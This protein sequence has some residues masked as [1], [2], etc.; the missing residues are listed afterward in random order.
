MNFCRL[1]FFDAKWY[2]CLHEIVAAYF[3]WK[4]LGATPNCFLKLFEKWDKVLKPVMSAISETV[5][6]PSASNSAARLSL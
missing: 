5:C 1:P 4:S 6:F 2:S 3:L